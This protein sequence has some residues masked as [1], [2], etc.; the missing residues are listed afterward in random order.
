MSFLIFFF[1]SS[2]KSENRRAE[3]VLSRGGVGTSGRREVVA[4]G[5]KRVNTVQKHM[6]VNAKIISVETIPGM[7]GIKKSSGG[8]KFKNDIFDTL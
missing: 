6:Y 4:K 5:G 1:L 8:G 3:Q 7:G 2:T